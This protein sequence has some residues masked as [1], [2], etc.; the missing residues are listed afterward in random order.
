MKSL[1]QYKVGATDGDLGK[2]SDF[3]FDDERWVIRYMVADTT[4]FWH[5]AHRVLVSPIAFREVDWSARVFHLALTQ[6]KLAHSPSVDVDKPVSRQYESDL[7]QYYGWSPY[8]GYAGTFDWGLGVQPSSLRSEPWK[9][10]QRTKNDLHLRSAMEVTHYGVQATDGHIG[11]ISDFIVDDETWNIRYVVVDT[12]PWWTGKHVLVSPS[13][14]KRV[15]WSDREVHFA[16][17]REAIKTAPEWEA[18]TSVDRPYEERLHEHH[19]RRGYWLAAEDS[20][21]ANEDP[22]QTF[23]P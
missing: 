3:F 21:G 8:W 16:V 18:G 22:A 10:V 4:G 23:R 9:N 5:Q 1:E 19:R 14:V 7:G 11:R 17:S 2:V 15:S 20:R 12:S 13:W 6:D